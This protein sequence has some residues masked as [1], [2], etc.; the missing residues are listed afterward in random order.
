MGMLSIYMTTFGFL[1]LFYIDRESRDLTKAL[2][3]AKH[4]THGAI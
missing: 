1:F 2:I 3:I 4:L